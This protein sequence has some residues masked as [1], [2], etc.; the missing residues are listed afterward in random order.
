[1][2]ERAAGEIERL[3]ESRFG[4]NIGLFEN[5]CGW[6][7]ERYWHLVLER[8]R[9]DVKTHT[10]FRRVVPFLPKLRYPD[11]GFTWVKGWP[12]NQLVWR[13]IHHDIR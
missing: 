8:A 12:C 13:D 6:P 10:K 2:C 1:L 3:P 4:C 9:R 7:S 11:F 5:G